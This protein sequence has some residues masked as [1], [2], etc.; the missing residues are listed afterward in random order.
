MKREIIEREKQP[1]IFCLIITFILGLFAHAYAF[2]NSNFSHDCLNAFYSNS[3]EIAWKIELGRFFVPVYQM[4]TKGKFTLPWLIGILSLFYVSVAVYIVKK[5]FDIRSNVLVAFIAGILVTNVTFISQT[6]TYIH[7]LDCNMFAMLLAVLTAFVWKKYSNVN[8]I[9]L[10]TILLFISMGIYQSYVSVTVALIMII[11]LMALLNQEETRIV[12]MRAIKG[13]LLVLFACVLYYI[14]SSFV[15]YFTEVPLAD[16]VSVFTMDT[17]MNP[18]LYYLKLIGGAYFHF[19]S[20]IMDFKI[21]EP[22]IIIPIVLAFALLFGFVVIYVFGRKKELKLTN[23]ILIL[24]IGLFLPLGMNMTYVLARGIVHDV[25]TFSFWFIYVM[26]LILVWWFADKYK[27]VFKYKNV[28]KIISLFLVGVLV[29]QN[30]MLSNTAYIKKDVEAKATLSTM[31][32]VVELMEEQEN[33]VMGETIVAFIGAGS[34][35]NILD[36]FDNVGHIT[37]VG[38][39]NALVSSTSVY[40]YNTYKAYFRYVLNYP[41]NICDDTTHYQLEQSE[42]V[43]EMPTFPSKGCIKMIDN[44]LV[45]KLGE[46]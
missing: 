21:Y 3:S 33:Y 36:E 1:F 20:C 42:S 29:W 14:T 39:N 37:G 45:I 38:L 31:T 9:L 13:V 27:D 25:M 41:L 44:I 15:C 17:D 24:C 16:R 2:L 10:G 22:W 28:L 11:S 30:I 46:S 7:E 34:S 43:Q 4:F 32:R 26:F 12:V 40:Y 6:A 18:I 5:L 35:Y 19:A 23:K 8:G